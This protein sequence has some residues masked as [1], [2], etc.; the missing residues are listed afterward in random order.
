MLPAVTLRE[1]VSKPL[2]LTIGLGIQSRYLATDFDSDKNVWTMRRINPGEIE[3]AV[4]P[5]EW[6]QGLVAE[7]K[8]VL[9]EGVRVPMD[10]VVVEKGVVRKFKLDKETMVRCNF[11]KS[12]DFFE[13]STSGH[14]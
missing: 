10:L 9:G 12:L 6:V 11:K 13:L 8:V 4:R 1:D 5:D 2:L 14:L 3:H 7:R